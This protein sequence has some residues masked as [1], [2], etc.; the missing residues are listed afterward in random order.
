MIRK[1]LKLFGFICEW[2]WKRFGKWLLIVCCLNIRVEVIFEL[3]L[4]WIMVYMLWLRRRNEFKNYFLNRYELSVVSV[5]D[6]CWGYYYVI[7]WIS[8]EIQMKRVLN[9]LEVKRNEFQFKIWKPDYDGQRECSL[10]LCVMIDVA[11][12]IPNR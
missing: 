2:Y 6:V 8:F 12:L 9:W 11:G 1:N 10:L 3:K 5:C 7:D 4:V